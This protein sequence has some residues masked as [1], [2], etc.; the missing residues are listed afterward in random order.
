[1]AGRKTAREAAEAV[2][3]ATPRRRRRPTRAQIEK[4]AYYISLSDR[5]GSP[6]E[7]WLAAER[8]LLAA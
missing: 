2:T 1:M 4:R 8:E 7:N 3:T 5:G 6:L